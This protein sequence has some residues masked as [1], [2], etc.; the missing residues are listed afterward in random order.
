MRC[1][2]ADRSSALSDGITLL[3]AQTYPRLRFVRKI[4]V[5]ETSPDHSIPL[6][7]DAGDGKA[8]LIYGLLQYIENREILFCL[9]LAHAKR[10]QGAAPSRWLIDAIE[11]NYYDQYQQHLAAI[12]P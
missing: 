1:E 2:S 11:D 8:Y 4:A 5:L 3:L 10:Q 6:C 12:N 7:K 9:V